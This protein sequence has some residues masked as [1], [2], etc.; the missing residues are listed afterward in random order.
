MVV[1]AVPDEPSIPA[2]VGA[3]AAGDRRAETVLCRRF[4]AAVRTFW[5]R[6]LRGAEVDELTQETMLRFV[7]SLRSG[8]VAEPERVGGFI[9]GICRNLARERARVAE[10]RAEL[11]T[12]FS[13]ALASL[14]DEPTLA[15]YQLAQL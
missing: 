9:L 3:A 13:S 4:A 5:R 6:R 2:L 11:W 10:R 15:R 8:A 7:Q 1:F 14:E 12:E